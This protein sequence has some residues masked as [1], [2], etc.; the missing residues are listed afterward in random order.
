MYA[1]GRM[2]RKLID[3]RGVSQANIVQATGLTKQNVS[4]ICKGKTQYPSIRACKLIADYF[5]MTLDELWELLEK[6]EMN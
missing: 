3:E 5:D 6:E 2:M 4:V 1:F